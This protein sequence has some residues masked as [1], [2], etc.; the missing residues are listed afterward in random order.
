MLEKGNYNEA[1]VQFDKALLRMPR[2]S[3]SLIGKLTALKA[4]DKQDEAE[5]IRNE[6]KAILAQADEKAIT[7]I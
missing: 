2:R 4:L 3:K 7:S 5:D 1:I 6:L